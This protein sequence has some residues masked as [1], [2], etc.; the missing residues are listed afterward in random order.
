MLLDKLNDEDRESAQKTHKD[1]PREYHNDRIRVK[2]KAMRDSL[3]QLA[4]VAA[5]VDVFVSPHR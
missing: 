3:A 2:A 5:K 4:G 1:I